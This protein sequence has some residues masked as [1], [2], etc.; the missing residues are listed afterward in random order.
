MAQAVLQNNG[1]SEEILGLR[2]S[3]VT[4]PFIKMS[5]AADH[6]PSL[7]YCKFPILYDSWSSSVFLPYDTLSK[8]IVFKYTHKGVYVCMCRCVHIC[9]FVSRLT[10]YVNRHKYVWISKYSHKYVSKNIHVY[11]YPSEY[12]CVRESARSCECVRVCVLFFRFFFI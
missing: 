6:H 3:L 9:L 8:Y 11:T 2:S 5:E 4:W 12:V 10:V 7:E 1:F